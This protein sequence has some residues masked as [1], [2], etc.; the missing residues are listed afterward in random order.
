MYITYT[1][2]LLSICKLYELNTDLC[3]YKE[4]E[5]IADVSWISDF[6]YVKQLLFVKPELYVNFES[7]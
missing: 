4:E 3:T 7:P 5:C 6:T 1:G 2:K